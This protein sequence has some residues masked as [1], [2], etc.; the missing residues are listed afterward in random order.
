MRL[1]KALSREGLKS[2]KAGEP[3]ASLGLCSFLTILLVKSLFYIKPEFSSVKIVL[4]PLILSL[5]IFKKEFGSLRSV[6]PI[7]WLQTATRPSLTLL[8]QPEQTHFPQPFPCVMS[9]SSHPFW[10]PPLDSF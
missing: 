5:C 4:L 1:L 8:L 6:I 2:S 7:K 10:W 9:S 3:I